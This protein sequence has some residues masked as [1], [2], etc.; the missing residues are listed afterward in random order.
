MPTSQNGWPANDRSLVASRLVP[1]TALRLTVRK[2]AAGDLLLWVAQQFDLWVEDI[3]N[4]GQLDDW[5]YAERP[6]RGGTALSNHASGTAIDLNAPRHPLGARGTFTATQVTDIRQI[7][8]E[9]GGAVR[10]GGDYRS[11]GDEMHF[12]INTDAAGV[13]R[14]WARIQGRTRAVTK[15]AP[16]APPRDEDDMTPQQAAQL[17]GLVTNT[18]TT[19]AR[20]ARIEAALPG[21]AGDANRGQMLRLYRIHVD[22]DTKAEGA[23]YLWTG[24]EVNHLTSGELFA[25]LRADG[26]P[27][28]DSTDAESS[29]QV[30]RLVDDLAS[31]ADQNSPRLRQRDGRHEA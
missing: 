18:A 22:P 31:A 29:A 30:A 21:I 2:D 26:W 12:E 7:L 23:V 19:D 6:V 14:A 11:R 1:G 28:Q 13:Q 15:A 27:C 25:R 3:D 10:W 20:L 17:S 9:T 5:G 24:G 4:T 16:P 8:A